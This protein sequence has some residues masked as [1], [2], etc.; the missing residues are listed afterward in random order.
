MSSKVIVRGGMFLFVVLAIATLAYLTQDEE[1]QCSD[2]GTD[3]TAAILADSEGD[4]D[5]LTNRAIIMK[6]ACDKREQASDAERV[7]E[8]S[9]KSQSPQA[10]AEQTSAEQQVTPLSRKTPAPSM[11]ASSPVA[12]TT[13]TP[14]E[15]LEQRCIVCHGCYDAPCQL[16]LEAQ[17][18]L[19][20]GASKDKVYD[21]GRLI[22]A[23][24]TRL[25]DDAFTEK[26]W[27]D[28][29]FYPVLDEEDP[30]NG[31]LYRLLQLKQAHPL[32]TDGPMPK[33]FDFSLY[34]DQQCP[35]PDEFDEYAREKPLWGMP[36][37]FPG[38]NAEQH[39]TLSNWILAGAPEELPKPLTKDQYAMLERWES[40]LNQ[41]SLR[42]QLMARYIYE[43]LFLASLYLNAEDETVWFRLVRSRTPPGE[44]LDL[45]T[46]RRPYDDP[47]VKR[48]HYRLQRMP[49]TTLAKTHMPYRIDQ[50]RLDWYQELFIDVDYDVK[51]LPGYDP[52]VSS[53]PFRTFRALPINSRYQFLLEESRFT[54]M[55]FIKG[56]VRR[57]QIALNVIDDHF[58]VLFA[59]PKEI[60][61]DL[62]AEFLANE[63][64]NLG[65]P[66]PKT[67]TII[68]I[69]RWRSYSKANA[70]YQKARSKL[71]TQMLEEGQRLSLIHI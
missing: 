61:V 48:V 15:I 71:I 23:N 35:K 33:G 32:A 13:R 49:V 55:N 50:A 11:P 10:S 39:S 8:A 27:R 52:N 70:S 53:N 18:G 6:G 57:G 59:N 38:L 16:K 21:G 3:M 24:V 12:V 62:D 42:H 67:G 45:I 69:L 7:D 26:G 4:Q 58:W 2:V 14:I 63:S 22:A 17:V 34:R 5:A 19:E 66:H 65:L 64:D 43:H 20:R 44:P 60:D 28:K 30:K 31:T 25:F 47:G 9:E 54:I 56:P 1:P 40:F 68:D 46:T 29:G 41:P 51:K 37:G 36:Y